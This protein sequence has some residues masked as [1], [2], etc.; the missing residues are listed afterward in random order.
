MCL[1]DRRGFS[2]SITGRLGPEFVHKVKIEVIRRLFWSESLGMIRVFPDK[3]HK[4]E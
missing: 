1:S 2:V 4:R 3:N